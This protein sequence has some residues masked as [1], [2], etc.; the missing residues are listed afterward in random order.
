MVVIAPGRADRP[1]AGRATVEPP[2]AGE[3]EHCPFC[4][5]HED[6]TPPEAFALAPVPREPDTPGWSVRVV[7][8]L[9]PALERQE[10]LVST[11]R[12]ARSLAELD[13]AELALIAEAWRSRA[14][15]ASAAGFGYVQALLNEGREAG[16]SLPH[17]HTQLAWIREVPPAVAAERTRAGDCGVCELVAR[18]QNVIVERGGVVVMAHPAGRLPYELLIAPAEHEPDGFGDRLGV[19]LALLAEAIRRLHAAVGGAV[20]L[21]AWLHT[22]GHWHLEVVPRLT[23]MAGLELGAGIYVNAVAPEDAATALREAI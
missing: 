15:A 18:G 17:S 19:A 12:H 1:G 2:S 6:R 14:A 20:P 5:G 11:P 16:A 7:P 10:V 9:Y 21:N 13:D 8:N 3:L 4:E 23:V 22:G